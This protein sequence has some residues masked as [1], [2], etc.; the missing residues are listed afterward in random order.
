MAQVL[1]ILKSPGATLAAVR[2]LCSVMSSHTSPGA[3]FG[4]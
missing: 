1:G 3:M 4:L 2:S